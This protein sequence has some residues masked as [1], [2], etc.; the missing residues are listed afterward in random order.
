MYSHLFT[1]LCVIAIIVFIVSRQLRAKPVKKWTF[2]ILPILAMYEVFQTFPREAV[3][4]S[5]WIECI[6]VVVGAFVAGT[7]QAWYSK[8]YVQ[9]HVVYIKGTTITLITWSAFIA[10]RVLLGFAFGEFSTGFHRIPWILWIGIAVIFG[11]RS[12][13]LYAKSPEIK[14]IFAPSKM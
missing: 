14:M 10:F 4:T 3:P 11:T 5:Q 9:N 1:A 2:V 7:I 8:V 12:L 6:L 13:I